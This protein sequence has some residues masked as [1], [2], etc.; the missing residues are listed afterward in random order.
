MATVNEMFASAISEARKSAE[1]I[2][3]HKDKAMAYAAIAS[4]LAQTGL[5]S[6]QKTD[7]PVDAAKEKAPAKEEKP[8]T[9]K[10]NAD[11]MK[12]QPQDIAPPA[13][14][15]KPKAEEKKD[16][17]KF[18]EEWTE[19]AEAHFGEELEY[20]TKFSENWGDDG[21]DECIKEFSDGVLK[22]ANDINPLN[23]VALVQ[24]LKELEAQQEDS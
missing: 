9:T 4:A 17:P 6:I 11:K 24:Y 10:K 14:E 21:L 22:T 2:A 3:D 23:I 8:A 7:A 18:T 13:E 12:R 20:I 19:Q 16:E 15:E 5:V 1:M